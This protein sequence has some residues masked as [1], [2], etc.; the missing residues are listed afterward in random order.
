MN[1][2]FERILK[3]KH[4]MMAAEASRNP[5]LHP[6]PSAMTNLPLGMT[7]ENCVQQNQIVFCRDHNLLEDAVI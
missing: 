5:D 1:P 7:M 2:G 6:G 3:E 4:A